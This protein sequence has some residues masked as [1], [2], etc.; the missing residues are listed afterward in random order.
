MRRPP[1]Y[2]RAPAGSQLD[3]FELVLRRLVEE[4][5]QITAPPATE[6][7]REYSDAGSVDVVRRRLQRS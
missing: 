2:R 4:W 5:P 3:C 7:L 6:V 1:R